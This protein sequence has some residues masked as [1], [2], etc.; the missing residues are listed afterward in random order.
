MPLRYRLLAIIVP[1]SVILDQITKAAVRHYFHYEEGGSVQVIPG[2]F[3]LV[4]SRNPGAAW[5]IFATL[6]PDALRVALFIVISI[7]AVAVVASLARKSRADQRV[8]VSALPLILGRALGNIA[9][10]LI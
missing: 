9:D 3:N 8:R 10:G 5:N 7:V 4:Y 2:L 6:R 1:L